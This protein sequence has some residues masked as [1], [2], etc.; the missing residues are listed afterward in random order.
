M[1]ELSLIPDNTIQFD[2]AC[3]YIS[4]EKQLSKM[5]LKHFLRQRNSEHPI[6]KAQR[7]L[8]KVLN[9]LKKTIFLT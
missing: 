4:H 2:K 9:K 6:I 8:P 5:G 7:E 1:P 3:F